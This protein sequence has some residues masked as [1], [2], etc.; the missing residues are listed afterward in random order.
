MAL[1]AVDSAHAHLTGT[2]PISL[3]A[4]QTATPFGKYLLIKRLAVGGM[5]ELFLAQ[6][7]PRSELLVIKRILPYLS[8]EPEFVQMFLDEARIAAQLHHPN[9]VQLFELGR[10]DNS[11]FIAMEFVDGID[12]RRVMAEESKH[13]ST[14]PYGVAARICARVAA[15]LDHAHHSR[16][17]DGRP[18]ELIHRDVSPQNVMVAYDGRVKLV[19]FG[20]AKAQSFAERS[21]PGVIKGKFL[22]LAPEQ[23]GQERLDGRADIFALGV[24]LYEL[25]TGRSPFSRPTT[26][27]ILYAIRSEMPPAPHLLRSDYPVALSRIVMKCLAK[28][29]NQ[30]Y[31]R[32]AAVQADLE[33]FLDS[34]EL[35][36]SVDISEYIARLMGEEDERTV[37][38]I[39]PA[40]A[41]RHEATIPMPSGLT[42][43]PARKPTLDGTPAAP[44]DPD[45]EPPTQMTRMSSIVRPERSPP[46]FTPPPEDEEGESTVQERGIR[47]QRP[48][49]S[50]PLPVARP[51]V[52]Q[53]PLNRS[54]RSVSTAPVRRPPLPR[55]DDDEPSQ[56]VSLTPAT[57]SERPARLMPLGRRAEESVADTIS[58]TDTM[59]QEH[60]LEDEEST[61]GYDSLPEAA[62]PPR[63]RM[64]GMVAAVSLALLSL[65]GAGLFWFMGAGAREAAA[66]SLPGASQVA[67]TPVRPVAA[68]SQPGAVPPV[69]TGAEA[70]ND[71]APAANAVAAAVRKPGE[72]A[73][74]QPSEPPPEPTPALVQVRF[75]A[76]KGT[77]LELPGRRKVKPNA[78]FELAEGSYRVVYRC[79]G[80]RSPRRWETYTVKAEGEA[81]VSLKVNCRIRSQR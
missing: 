66:P 74:A 42:S 36:Q 62:P 64:G 56:S 43:R 65:V 76:P 19:D 45:P 17:V 77:V 50:T 61:I 3:T 29:R 55:V 58:R 1:R 20:I 23:V 60:D 26:E 22:Y 16:G 48:S 33:A 21:K 11:I 38:H 9:I 6:Q 75:D 46:R 67:P 51:S 4:P 2:A 25:T 80:R 27:A 7:A 30:R 40:P 34:G 32:A 37:L 14:V 69:D 15:G 68:P 41:S 54:R 71:M 12:L 59:Q 24:M 63:R 39:P 10:Q 49:Q 81:P 52:T 44:A 18:L 79:P 13:G 78:L 72:G 53:E 57:V 31:P 70:R 73:E 8:E 35:R 5:A 47:R 28:D